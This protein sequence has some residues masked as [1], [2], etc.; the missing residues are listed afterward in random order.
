MA[1]VLEEAVAGVVRKEGLSKTKLPIWIFSFSPIPLKGIPKVSC[2][3]C[4]WIGFFSMRKPH[5]VPL[6]LWSIPKNLLGLNSRE[7][8]TGLTQHQEI[9]STG[10]PRSQS[11]V[12][13]LN[14]PIFPNIRLQ[15]MW[16]VAVLYIRI[17]TYSY[18]LLLPT[19]MSFNNKVFHS[20]GQSIVTEI[21]FDVLNLFVPVSG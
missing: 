8:Q 16:L 17:C 4:L 15:I 12:T 11:K 21:I 3:L 10:M 7:G 1:L 20:E 2:E 6:S 5:P 14:I 13:G 9:C 19:S 18:F